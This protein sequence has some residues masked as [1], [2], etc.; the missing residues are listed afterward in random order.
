VPE[1]A[2][3]PLIAW[4][5]FYVITGSAAGALTGLT[6]VVITLMP[7]SRARGSSHGVTA[8]STPTV[9]HFSAALL[10]SAILSA[11]WQAL[12][13]AGLVLG[14][15]ALAGVAYAAI[16]VRRVRRSTSYRPDW[17]DWLWYAILPLVAYTALVVAA[18]LLPSSPVPAL[19]GVGAGTVLLL[20]TGI[21]NAWDSVTYL[22]VHSAQ[23]QNES[24]D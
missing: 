7:A 4:Q 10:V 9:V 19:F 2:V 16:A 11:P 15:A 6:F 5:S 13:Q 20:F 21:H 18:I 14:L 17:E 1:A 8:F 23:P 24:S 22:A 3:S 12:W